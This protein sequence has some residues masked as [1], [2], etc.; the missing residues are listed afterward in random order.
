M[1]LGFFLKNTFRFHW[2]DRIQ[3]R[4]KLENEDTLITISE[5]RLFEVFCETHTTFLIILAKST[6]F[7][8]KIKSN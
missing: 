8:G 1:L 7:S 3:K 5:F 2:H 6:Q 4:L